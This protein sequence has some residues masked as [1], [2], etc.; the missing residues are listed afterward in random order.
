[1]SAALRIAV[2]ASGAGTNLQAIL[3]QL[4]GGDEGIEV[5]GVGSDKPDATALE[6]ARQAGIEVVAVASDKAGAG[7]LERARGTGVET[8]VFRRS[9]HPDRESRDLAIADWLERRRVELVVLAGYMQLLSPAFV[10]RFAN[11]VINVHPALLPSFPGL[12]AVGQALEHG[13]RVTGVT[14]HFVDVGVDSGPIILQRPVP[15]PADRD[16]EALERAIRAT[17]HELL[18]QAIRMIADGRVTIESDS[19]RVAISAD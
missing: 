17:E 1:M 3:D 5:V 16:R 9:D 6:R 12:D 10:R 8:A 14:V 7:A 2:L 19:R 13:V 4:H 18:P 15:V 11:R